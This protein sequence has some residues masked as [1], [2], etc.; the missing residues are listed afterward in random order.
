MSRPDLPFP[1]IATGDLDIAVLGQLPTANLPFGDEFEPGPVNAPP[2]VRGIHSR[3]NPACAMA[4]T[5]GNGSRRDCSIS[6]ADAW[7]C[8]ANPLAASINPSSGI[9]SLLSGVAALSSE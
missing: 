4:S 2:S 5:N 3:K 7:I 8:G 1:K 6:S 9:E